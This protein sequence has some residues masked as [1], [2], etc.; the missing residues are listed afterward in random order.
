M[1]RNDWEQEQNA[2]CSV[3]LMAI[4]K[5]KFPYGKLTVAVSTLL[6]RRSFRFHHR[7]PCP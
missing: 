6:L 3:F 2:N 5:V 7:Q 1:A 4:L